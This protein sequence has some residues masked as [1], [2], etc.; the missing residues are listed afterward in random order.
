MF[1]DLRSLTNR[2]IKMLNCN[3]KHWKISKSTTRLKR[4]CL[5]ACGFSRNHYLLVLEQ[6]FN[7]KSVFFFIFQ[8]RRCKRLISF[9]QKS[10]IK[11]VWNSRETFFCKFLVK[12]F[13]SLRWTENFSNELVCTLIQFKTFL[14][15]FKS[16]NILQMN[17][18][19]IVILGNF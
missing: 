18:I 16:I 12:R 5:S 3:L 10:W 1:S 11:F 9:Q 4:M 13:T 7:K 2:V 17:N 14:L 19:W 8:W 15:E 6:N